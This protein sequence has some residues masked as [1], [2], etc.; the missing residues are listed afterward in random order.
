MGSGALLT[1]AARNSHLLCTGEET[2]I[3]ANRS[4]MGPGVRPAAPG[5]G[6]APT[7][8]AVRS[9]FFNDGA[10]ESV[11]VGVIRCGRT[12]LQ[13]VHPGD[14]RVDGTAES[15]AGLVWG[16]AEDEQGVSVAEDSAGSSPASD[17]AIPRDEVEVHGD[18]DTH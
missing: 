6:A 16:D 4:S 9:P 7:G 10:R 15:A 11:A 5:T 18:H 12:L 17:G 3:D 14:Y 13:A 8:K 2:I 1:H